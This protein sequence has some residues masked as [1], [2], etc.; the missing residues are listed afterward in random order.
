MKKLGS[1]HGQNHHRL[2]HLFQHGLCLYSLLRVNLRIPL[3]MSS[4]SI[5]ISFLFLGPV[6]GCKSSGL[7]EYWT[8]L[9]FDWLPLFA[10]I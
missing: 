2:C 4:V 5:T 6:V 1:T 9:K 8:L 10:E 3:T 7:S